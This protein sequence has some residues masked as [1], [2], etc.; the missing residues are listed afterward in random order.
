MLDLSFGAIPIKMKQ[1]TAC[2]DSLLTN[3]FIYCTSPKM[4]MPSISISKYGA[5]L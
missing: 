2:K 5:D 4:V 3:H 1:E